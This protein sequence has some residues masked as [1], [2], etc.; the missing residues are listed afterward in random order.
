MFWFPNLGLLLIFL[1]LFASIFGIFVL[2]VWIWALIDCLNSEKNTSDKL[3]WILLIVLFNIIGAILYFILGR[4][5]EV[6]QM[7]K[8]KFKGKRLL[9]SKN[10]M[11]A[12]VCGGIAEYFNIDPTIVRILWVLFTF[13]GG[14]GIL[15]YIIAWIIIPE[16]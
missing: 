2:V 4:S 14:A 5:K 1:I 11:I 9:R 13:A 8:T 12:G 7:G 15:A 3:L 16:R 6:K 10:R